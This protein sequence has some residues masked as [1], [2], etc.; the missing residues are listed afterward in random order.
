MAGFS[1]HLAI[2]KRYIE[3]HKSE[4][5]Y[6]EEYYRGISAPDLYE[7]NYK[8]KSESH[9]GMWGDYQAITNIDEFL[10]DSKVDMNK[11]YWKGYFLTL[12]FQVIPCLVLARLDALIKKGQE[13]IKE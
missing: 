7:G 6:E 4:I 10:K 3:K 13:I 8:N 12:L 5:E 1:I 9:Y 11:D 2:G